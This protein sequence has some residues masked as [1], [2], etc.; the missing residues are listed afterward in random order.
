[1]RATLLL[2]DA[3]QAVGGKLFVLGG[4]WSFMR[5]H[6]PFGIA[7]KI[8]V[9]WN[10]ALMPHEFKLELVDADGGTARVHLP[11]REAIEF[12]TFDGKIEPSI[13][14]GLPPG[15]PVDHV[16]A[17]NFGPT[18][19]S[20]GRYEFRLSIDGKSR[21]EW[22]IGFHQFPPAQQAEAA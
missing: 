9:P 8:D 1:M 7:V 4:G 5:G 21:T 20:P 17:L 3:V 14:P 6:V 10:E 11:D 13:P 22:S 15:T 2:A 16:F 19:L 18:P 12:P